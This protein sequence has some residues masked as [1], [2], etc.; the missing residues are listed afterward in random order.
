M[1]RIK[2]FIIKY[3]MIIAIIALVGV[4]SVMYMQNIQSIDNADNSYEQNPNIIKTENGTIN[5]TEKDI[6]FID[7]FQLS[8]KPISDDINCISSAAKNKDFNETTRC[9]KFLEED[10]NRSLRQIDRFTEISPQFRLVLDEYKKSLVEYNIGASYLRTG[11][12]SQNMSQMMNAT[13]HIKNGTAYVREAMS[14]L[15]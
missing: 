14:G 2:N 12:A 3:P 15:V 5:K 10:S 13:D 7:W 1:E 9:A 8:Y 6:E 11:A 4:M